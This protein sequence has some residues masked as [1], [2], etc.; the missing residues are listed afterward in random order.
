MRR[1]QL[2]QT[3]YELV[4][5]TIK[6]SLDRDA[7]PVTACGRQD[8]EE[9][10]KKG[11]VIAGVIG[12]DLTQ[13]SIVVSTAPTPVIIDQ[14]IL[15]GG[16]P[17]HPVS[18]KGLPTPPAVRTAAYN[19]AQALRSAGRSAKHS[20]AIT[21]P[22]YL[23]VHENVAELFKRELDAFLPAGVAVELQ[24]TQDKAA[25]K[26]LMSNPGGYLDYIPLFSVTSIDYAIDWIQDDL[27][28]PPAVFVFASAEFGKYVFRSLKRVKN[29]VVN[30]IP[31]KFIGESTPRICW[32]IRL[33][34]LPV[35]GPYHDYRDFR[36]TARRH[37]ALQSQPTEPSTV[38][39]TLTAAKVRALTQKV[40]TRIDFFGGSECRVA[41]SWNLD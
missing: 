8:L 6:R 20:N 36:I 2:D 10:I 22:S 28:L 11:G 12:A 39:T 5:P 13:T 3:T 4:H 1:L 33:I 24:G 27:E 29:V 30:D 26:N 41:H 35:C 40:G 17:L 15:P 16:I 7:F 9:G 18:G 37:L 32:C 21:Y 38:A 25:V 34:L 23:V 31:E 14:S 19:V